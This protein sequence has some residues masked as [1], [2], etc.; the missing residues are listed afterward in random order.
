MYT[1]EYLLDFFNESLAKAYIGEEPKHLYEPIKYSLSAGGKRIRPVLCLLAADMFGGSIDDAINPAIALEMFHNFTLLHD[2]MMDKAEMR[3][4]KPSVHVKWT[5]N[6]ALLSG[7][8]MSIIAYRFISMACINTHDVIQT[9]TK[10]SLEICEGQQYDM[11]FETQDV[12][13][14]AEYLNM[15]N[16]KTAVLFAGS[17]KIGALTAGVR[18][19]DRENIYQFGRN[20][21]MAFQLQDDLLDVFGN[22]KVFGKNIGGDIV[23]NKKTYLLIKALNE[24]SPEQREQLVKWLQKKDFV[25]EEKIMAV[26][27]IYEQ[28]NVKQETIDLIEKYFATANKYIEAINVDPERKKELLGYV[29]SLKNRNY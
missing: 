28:L 25:P 27:S 23:S 8:A 24:A 6:I 3:R 12:V 29:E 2:D 19:E 9:F 10:T 20:V 15:I 11:N 7:D 22:P 1:N 16:L 13:S 21:G 17:L 18:S 5:D 26:K 4:G 14:E